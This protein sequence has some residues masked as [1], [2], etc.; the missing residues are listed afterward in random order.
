MFSIEEKTKSF[1][2]TFESESNNANFLRTVDPIQTSETNVFTIRNGFR[3]GVEK[4]DSGYRVKETRIYVQLHF[5]SKAP[6]TEYKEVYRIFRDLTPGQEEKNTYFLVVLGCH[7][8]TM[9]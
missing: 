9:P 5:Q 2:R 3:S 1:P 8:R 6:K 4:R 7:P